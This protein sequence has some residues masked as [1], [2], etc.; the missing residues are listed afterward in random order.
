MVISADIYF[1]T[2]K[3]AR[4]GQVMAVVTKTTAGGSNMP[5][6]VVIPTSSP[7]LADLDMD[8]LLITTAIESRICVFTHAL[9]ATVLTRLWNLVRTQMK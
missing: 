6:D 8:E 7:E 3:P 2:E 1:Y 4:S 5:E 9:S